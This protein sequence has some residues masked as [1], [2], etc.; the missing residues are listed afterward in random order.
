MNILKLKKNRTALKNSALVL[1]I[2]LSTLTINSHAQQSVTTE[3]QNI[4]APSQQEKTKTISFMKGKVYELVYFTVGEGKQRQLDEEYF[5]ISMPIVAEYGGK[6]HGMFL[7]DNIR[8][9]NLKGKML[10]IFEWPSLKVK[11]KM[12]SDPRFKKV[13]P[14]LMDAMSYFKPG[15]YEVDKSSDVTFSNLKSYEFFGAWIDSAEALNEYWKVTGPLKKSYGRPE[16]KFLLSLKA[17]GGQGMFD[18]KPDMSGIVEWD[19][20]S[21]YQ[22]FRDTAEFKTNAAQLID[23]ALDKINIV[24]TKVIIE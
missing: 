22:A 3:A 15:F 12:H 21:D 18:Y 7:I 6:F 13:A 16:P 4:N 24:Q 8:E 9:G 20:A 10:G 14:I 5:P 17:A 11:D 1:A 23:K 2:A 19:R